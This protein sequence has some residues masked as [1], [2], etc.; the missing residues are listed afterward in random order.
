MRSIH[1]TRTTAGD[2]YGH[3]TKFCGA[4]GCSAHERYFGQI[5][6]AEEGEVLE[7]EPEA[8]TLE[9]ESAGSSEDMEAA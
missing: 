5:E 6:G 1:I 9:E 7:V 2:T 4:D 8:I 3:S